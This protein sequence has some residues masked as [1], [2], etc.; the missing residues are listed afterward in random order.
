MNNASDRSVFDM[1]NSENNLSSFSQS[2]Q[3]NAV[4]FDILNENFQYKT[5]SQLQWLIYQ[6]KKL[7]NGEST[8]YCKVIDMKKKKK[9][10]Q[11]C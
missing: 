4:S 11:L 2:S 6:N 7:V 8:D 9:L 5:M 10:A 3:F 1:T